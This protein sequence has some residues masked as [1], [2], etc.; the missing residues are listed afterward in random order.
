MTNNVYQTTA[1]KHHRLSPDARRKW[2]TSFLAWGLI[3]PAFFFLCIFTLYPIGSSVYTSFFKDNLATKRTGAVFVG[4]GNYI[5]LVKDPVFVKSFWNNLI[6]ALVTIPTSIALA[7]G[8]AIFA[9]KVKIGK[10]FTRV[11]FFYPTLMPMVA[12][13]NI[14]L[15]IYTPQYGLLGY[16]NSSWRFLSDPKTAL[17]A[18]IVM[19]IWKQAGYVMIFYISGLQN[20]NEELYE[21]A[22]IDGANANQ[23]FR[24]ITWP[25]LRPTTIYVTII[26]LTNAYKLVDHLYILTKGGPNNST[27][28]LLFYVYQTGFDFWDVGKASTM[29]VV[30]VVILLIVTCVQFFV[31]DKR[32]HYS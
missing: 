21:A 26:T 29:T 18:I 3:L 23:V 14:W 16:L 19:L 7:V 20:I 27:N 6:I 1:L 13:A 17:W 30:L 22:R 5:G 24:T 11:A 31:Q 15:F 10:G 9:N 2:R 25:L 32:T 28:M 4:L 12:V 8:M